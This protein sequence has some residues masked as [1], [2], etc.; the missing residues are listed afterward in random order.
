MKFRTTIRKEGAPDSTIVIDAASRFEVYEQVQKEGG[1]VVDLT[2]HKW[3]L[4]LSKLLSYSIFGTGIKRSDVSLMAKNL[5]TMLSA[6]LS[7]ARALSVIERQTGNKHLKAVVTN[8]S[9]SIK[10]GSS[11]HEALTSYPKVFPGILTAMV[12]AG[13]ESGSLSDSLAVVG[14]QMER[15]EALTRKIKGAMIYPFI[16]ITAILIVSILMLIYVVPTLTKT[17]TELKVPLPT[18]TKLFISLS[19]FMVAYAPF[20]F[21]ALIAFVVGTIAFVRSR[22]GSAIVLAGALYVPVVGELIRETFAARTARTLSSLLSAGVPVLNALSITKEVVRDNAFA[23]VIEEAEERVKKGE[24]LS[25]AFAEH[26]KIYPILMSEMLSVGEETGKVA[27]M[28]KQVAEFYEEDVSEK[29]KDL[30]TIIEPVLMLLIGGVVGIFA[31]SMISPI[32]S[33]SSAI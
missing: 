24:P 29:T 6:G 33:L 30:S 15:A 12:R 16:I 4:S 20:V 8:I 14:L 7:L 27:P 23:R 19:N 31:V 5:A 25:I 17:F 32:Y 10:K 3:D 21:A 18:A 22:R 11:F 26:T 28:L 2:E 9:E 13:E 1:F